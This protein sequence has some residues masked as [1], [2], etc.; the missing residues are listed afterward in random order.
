M[1]VARDARCASCGRCDG[2]ACA[3]GAKA[4]LATTILPDLIAEGLVVRANAAVVRLL[5]TRDRVFAVEVA[6]LAAGRRTA[7]AADLFVLAAGALATPALLLHSG[8]AA[9]NPAGHLVGAGLMRH[10]N[11]VVTGLFDESAHS[12][13]QFQKEIG[14]HDF[15]E[16]AVDAPSGRLGSV[17]Q[18]DAGSAAIARVGAA[19]L[20]P[21]AAADLARRLAG[22]I[23]LAEDRPRR[24]NRVTISTARTD[25]LGGA[26]ALVRHRYAPRDLHARAALAQRARAILF[27][28]GA[29]ATA[30]V[31]VGG[32]AHALGGVRMGRDRRTAP[33]D[34]D[35]RFRGLAN[36]YVTDGSAFPTAGGVN[37]SLTI[38]AN[39]MRVGAAIVGRTRLAEAGSPA[40]GRAADGA[41]AP[42]GS[43]SPTNGTIRV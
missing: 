30:T 25:A 37:P 19:R 13:G 6:D 10:A 29:R 14:V 38:A 2:F 34:A 8:L 31:P 15:Y 32:F 18:L 36:L 33:L 12:A 1:A 20:A 24:S 35:G 4:D 9:R 22:L 16:G 28:A 43:S 42:A 5:W 26:V 7:V 3:V 17:Q 41:V 23:V 40:P 11:A 21:T 39:A 27:A